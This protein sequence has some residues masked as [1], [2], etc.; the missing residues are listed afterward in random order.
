MSRLLCTCL[1]SN[2]SHAQIISNNIVLFEDNLRQVL[3]YADDNNLLLDMIFDYNAAYLYSKKLPDNLKAKDR[4]YWEVFHGRD[5]L[6]SNDLLYVYRHKMCTIWLAI[7]DVK[8]IITAFSDIINAISWKALLLLDFLSIYDLSTGIY[9]YYEKELNQYICLGLSDSQLI[10]CRL[11]HPNQYTLISEIVETSDYMRQF[12]LDAKYIIKIIAT[13]DKQFLTEN[14]IDN[15]IYVEYIDPTHDMTVQN[16][17][18]Q[19]NT[20]SWYDS[21]AQSNNIAALYMKRILDNA[22]DFTAEYMPFVYQKLYSE[23]ENLNHRKKLGQFT[24]R[25]TNTTAIPFLNTSQYK[26]YIYIGFVILIASSFFLEKAISQT[27]HELRIINNIKTKT[28]SEIKN[29]FQT[30]EPPKYVNIVQIQDMLNQKDKGLAHVK[31][32]M[33]M[34]HEF[35]ALPMHIQY[36]KQQIILTLK[37]RKP[38]TYQEIRNIMQHFQDKCNQITKPHVA[39]IGHTLEGRIVKYTITVQY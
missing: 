3:S 38:D 11:F 13:A 1:V 10:T 5:F 30:N 36:Q 7:S 24:L 26:T 15:W 28:V 27:N 39:H 35:Q 20:V 22:L 14:C 29:T 16:I 32:I 19:E 8:D 34:I 4:S 37:I 21:L 25:I 33:D 18:Q 31:D 6:M 12:H 23:E 2:D 9:L 17:A